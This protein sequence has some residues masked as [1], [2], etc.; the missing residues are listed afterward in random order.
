MI[1]GGRKILFA[2][3]NISVSEVRAGQI[4]LEHFIVGVAIECDLV[5]ADGVVPETFCTKFNGAVIVLQRVGG[6]RC[7]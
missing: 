2:G 5:L 6:L 3:Q 4:A 7:R 1:D